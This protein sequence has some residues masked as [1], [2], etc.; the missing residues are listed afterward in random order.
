M[1]PSLKDK[2]A[3]F[4]RRLQSRS[5]QKRLEHKENQ[6]KY[7]KMTRRSR[8]HLRMSIYRDGLFHNAQTR[9]SY[10]GSPT[11]RYQAYIASGS[12]SRYFS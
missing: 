5:S 8:S 4:S 2:I 6:T 9:T 12:G 11:V 10:A 1:T 3:N 7:R